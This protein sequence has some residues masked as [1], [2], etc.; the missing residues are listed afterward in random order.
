MSSSSVCF[1]EVFADV[2][3]LAS[4]PRTPELSHVCFHRRAQPD[5]HQQLLAQ[6]LAVWP[7][8]SRTQI[9]IKQ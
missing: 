7:Q 1:S 4:R 3:S 9:F 5:D 8:D 2:S 6:L